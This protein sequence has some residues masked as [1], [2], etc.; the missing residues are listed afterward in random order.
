MAPGTRAQ[1]QPASAPG[2][3]GGEQRLWSGK[4]VLWGFLYLLPPWGREA[5]VPGGAAPTPGCCRVPLLSVTRATNAVEGL[6]SCTGENESPRKGSVAPAT[7]MA[8]SRLPCQAPHPLGAG[9][10]TQM[11]GHT[12][13]THTTT[14]LLKAGKQQQW[15]H[16][17]WL[18]CCGGWHGCRAKGCP[19]PLP[20]WW[21]RQCIGVWLGW[22]PWSGHMPQL[23]WGAGGWGEAELL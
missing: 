16:Q 13:H 18:P 22:W 17:C 9:K 8:P 15:W 23:C 7:I 6:H 10:E 21:G 14:T 3:V 19:A 4:G 1:C 2:S 12:F 11:S 5:G 20:S